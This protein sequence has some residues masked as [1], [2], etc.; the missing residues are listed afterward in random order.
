MI[1]VKIITPADRY[2]RTAEADEI[3]KDFL[4]D[5]D[6]VYE[7]ATVHMDGVPLTVSEMNSTFA[8]TGITD[9]CII[10]VVQKLVNA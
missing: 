8:D 2:E 6:V 7:A 5:N 9:K 3:I 1:T 10:A 4:N